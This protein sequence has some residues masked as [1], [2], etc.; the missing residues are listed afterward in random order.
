MV[1]FKPLKRYAHTATLIDNKLYILGG[2][3]TETNNNE[4]IGTQFFYLDVSIPFNTKNI[5]WH[6]LTEINIIPAHRAA[7][8]V[9]GGAYNNILF[10]YGGKNDKGDLELVYSFDTKSN[11]W[12]IPT[13]V[14]NGDNIKK[15][16]NVKGIVDD[17]GKMYLFSGNDKDRITFYDDMLILDT[18]NL[19]LNMGSLDNAP[20]KRILYG[21]TFVPNNFIIYFGK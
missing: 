16:H 20:I 7:A 8:S 6:D 17:N 15:K 18:I 9:R 12:S 2:R 13:L 21:A 3:V 14:G 4:H 19:N 5:L 10:L 1:S 11:S